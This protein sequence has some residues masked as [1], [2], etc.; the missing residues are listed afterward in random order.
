[1][2]NIQEKGNLVKND[3]KVGEPNVKHE[4]AQIYFLFSKS[5]WD[6]RQR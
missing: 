1:M 5:H 3:F 2:I 4:S 6:P